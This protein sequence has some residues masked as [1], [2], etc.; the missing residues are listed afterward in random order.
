MHAAHRVTFAKRLHGNGFFGHC[1]G[2]FAVVTCLV[3]NHIVVR[4]FH[5]EKLL[6][7]YVRYFTNI[8]IAVVC[9]Y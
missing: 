4:R 5:C 2:T 3:R 1:K 9:T 7:I 8:L 6:F